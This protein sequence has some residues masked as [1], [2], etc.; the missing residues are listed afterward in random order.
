MIAMS[1]RAASL[2]GVCLLA[3]TIPAYAMSCLIFPLS[4]LKPKKKYGE[5]ME[6]AV[7][8]LRGQQTEVYEVGPG[9]VHGTLDTTRVWFIW[10]K[11]GE[12]LYQAR[13]DETLLQMG[14]K[15]K[16]D[17][18]VGQ[19]VKVRFLDKKFMGMKSAWAVFERSKKKEWPFVLVSIIG[20][21]GVDECAGRFSCP[22][23]AEIDRAAREEEQ[24]ARLKGSGEKSAADVEPMPVAVSEEPAAATAVD[25]GAPVEQVTT[26][27]GALPAAEAAPATET[28]PATEAPYSVDAT[29]GANPA[30]ETVAVPTETPPPGS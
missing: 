6:A 18:W 13:R 10:F 29:P 27:V 4:C 15:P 23:Q 12:T 24:L 19:T 17:E 20:P 8:D 26:A 9:Y 25:T 3:F 5:D 14:Y 16:R 7:L 30:P 2:S 28:A 22:Q 21:D 11:V 1:R